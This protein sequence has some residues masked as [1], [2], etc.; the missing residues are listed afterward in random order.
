MNWLQRL[1][2]RGRLEREL[3]K[4][5]QYDF[6]L[7]I[8]ALLAEGVAPQEAARRARIEFGGADEIKEDCRDARG[9]RW[10][11]DFIQDSRYGLRTLRR[12]PVF[13]S[14]AILSLALGIGANTAIFSLMDRVMFRMMPVRHPE[15]LVQITRFHPPYGPVTVSY[16]LFQSLGKGLGSFEG[17]LTHSLLGVRDIAIDGN[18]E[19]ADFDLVSGSYYPLLGVHAVIGRTFDEDAD[20][21]PGAPAVAVISHRYWERRFASN[22][23]VIGKTFRRLDTVFTIVG[24]TPRDFFGTVVGKEPDIA[25]PITMDAQVR[26]GAS[27]L[28][29]PNYQWLSV[30]GRLKP[31]VG[32]DQARAEAKKV[33]ANIVAADAMSAQL[34]SDRRGRLGEYV[35]LQPGGNGFDNLRRRFAEPLTVLMGTVALVLLLACANLANLLLAKSAARRREIAVRLAIGAGR[36]RVI[37]QLVAEGLLLAVAGGTL[38]V[39][40]AYGFAEGL[41]TAMSNSGPRMLLDVAPN[42]RVLFFAAAVSTIACLL[43][44]LT[45]ALQATRQSFQPALAEARAGRWRLGKGLIVAQMAIAVLLL[46]GAGLFGRTLINIYSLD[47]GF[48]RHGVVLFSTN[49]AQLRYTRPRMQEMQIRVPAEL[50]ALPGVMS[51]SVSM[52]A[53]ISG[54]GWDGSFVV[55]GHPPT[56]SQND[57]SHVN[58]V[59]VDFFKTFH[60]PVV[61]GREFSQRDTA[62][63]LRVVI[64]NHAFARYYFPDQS[65]LGKWV[66]FQGPERD[67]HYRIVG[68]VKDVKYES[69]RH[70]FPRTIYM[71]NAQ[72]P[73]GPDS[74]TF[75][76]RTSAGMADAVQAIGTAL[77]HVDPELRP[78]SVVS[79]ESRVAQSLLQ[80]RMLAT[81]AAFFGAL[82]LLLGAVGI[83]G[84]MAFQVARRRREIGIRMALGADEGSVIGMVLGQ[85]ARLTLAG[86]AI[87]AAA[88]LALTRLAEGILYGVRAYDPP[89]FLTAA[90]GLMLIALA[91]AYLPGRSA[92]RTNPIETLRVD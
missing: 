1:F 30:M 16:P 72:V 54:G 12:S 21:A 60:T 33:F 69:L 52:F 45:P 22:P 64:V 27:W 80:E 24:V 76:V 55:E 88:G 25:V 28:H 41:V 68:V 79:L 32:I 57:I 87:G 84:T 81:L 61:L 4:E 3:D 29:E 34:D 67:T 36:S 13:T 40:L 56:G 92:A 77:A 51:A 42:A 75:A 74:Y 65:P 90:A 43:F 53:P 14:V 7:R 19:T 23:A 63:S 91:A 6:D 10:A 59:G 50:E 66:A 47:P 15:Q 38:G 18:P 46:I 82:A 83:Y 35:E 11:D 44:S 39:L 5:L 78:V 17:L 49:A 2:R 26:G 8:A 71:M 73:P 37:R 20:R 31:G 62:E 48:E 9:T 86:C 85:T 89:T 70:D 58:S